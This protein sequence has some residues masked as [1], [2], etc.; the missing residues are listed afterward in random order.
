MSKYIYD[1]ITRAEYECPCCHKLPPDLDISDPMYAYYEFFES[2]KTVREELGKPIRW[3]SGYRCPNHNYMVGGSPL[4]A[5]MWG[6]AGDWECE[7][8]EDVDKLSAI[9]ELLIPELRRKEY[10]KTATFIHA[11][12]A[13]LI[14]PRVKDSWTKFWRSHD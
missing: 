11:D 14:R 6:L 4:S 7:T 10:R 8:R 3:N 2:F 1:Y 5:H 13:Y 12:V 9:M